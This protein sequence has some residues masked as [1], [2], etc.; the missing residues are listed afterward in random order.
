MI[1]QT[2]VGTAENP[3]R[4]ENNLTPKNC[5][6]SHGIGVSSEVISGAIMLKII[7]CINQK[8]KFRYLTQHCKQCCDMFMSHHRTN[9]L[10]FFLPTVE[11]FRF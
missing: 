10:H 4:N 7:L 9:I 6:I 5:Q 11:N 8:K 3:D 1:N 2:D